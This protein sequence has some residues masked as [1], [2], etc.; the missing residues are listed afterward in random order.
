MTI[1]V[2]FHD[3]NA[4]FLE[5]H[6][7]KH[8]FTTWE[9]TRN[10]RALVFDGPV[11][12]TYTNPKRR[13]LFD[14]IRD[15]NPFFH[16]MEAIWMLSGS[17]EVEFPAKFAKNIGSYSDDGETLHGAYGYRWRR[18]F[19]TDQIKAVI[20][21][22][23]EDSSTRRAVIGMWDPMIDLDVDSRDLPCNTH[24]YFR[25][26][27][28]QLD[29]TVCNRSNDM[30]WGMLGANMV[31]MSILQEYIANALDRE[32]GNYYQFTNNLH[33][34]EG[35]EDKYAVSDSRWYAQHRIFQRWAFC[36][37]NLDL[38]EAADFVRSPDPAL[39]WKC[40]ILKDNA[41]PMLKAWEAYKNGR[42]EMALSHASNIRDE[43]WRHA[44]ME[45]LKR[46]NSIE[47]A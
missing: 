12:V 7:Q 30:V 33:I 31:H 11:L 35:W 28:G 4:A 5:L 25:V 22:L 43:D 1:H 46:R 36:P 26:V 23:D 39:E 10:G 2:T 19:G 9:S 13:V 24:I 40:R 44:C 20:R 34:Y 41:I 45:W 8:H 42:L 6:N 16:Y 38:L 27:K 18:H 21:M 17:E 37:R 47:E 3:I 29:M 32:V 14:P 15:A